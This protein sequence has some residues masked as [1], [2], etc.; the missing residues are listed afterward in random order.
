MSA[1]NSAPD[2]KTA[3]E[4]RPAFSSR[5]LKRTRS[6]L[7]WSLTIGLAVGE[8]VSLLLHLGASWGVMIGW[9][10]GAATLSGL[11]WG[12]V[13]L[14]ATPEITKARA[15]SEDPGRLTVLGILL[16]SS[17]LSLALAIYITSQA[18]VLTAE[19]NLLAA[20]CVISVLV[21]WFTMHTSFTLHYAHLYYR[22]DGTPGGLQFPGGEEPSDLDFAYFSFTL[23][24]AF[25]VSDVTVS[26][27]AF[28]A[29]VLMHALVSFIFNTAILAL[30]L[31]LAVGALG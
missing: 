31:N 23:G 30:T 12:R 16:T 14:P 15:A 8:G 1:P 4:D 28:R 3:L 24:M 2:T 6:S 19:A 9:V 25:Q 13:I 26:S 29:V 18:K 27:R 5:S 21:S 20:F 11:A 22:D 17:L 7:L 10:A